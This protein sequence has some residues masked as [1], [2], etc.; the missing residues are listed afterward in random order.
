MAY[1]SLEQRLELARVE[2]SNAK[3]NVDDVSTNPG[4]W[5]SQVDQQR[6]LVESLEREIRASA[7]GE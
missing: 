4:Y 7:E 5:K 1:M 3:R 6:R 2:L